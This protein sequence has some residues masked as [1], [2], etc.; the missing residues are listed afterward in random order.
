MNSIQTIPSQQDGNPTDFPPPPTFDISV[1]IPV[2]DERETI[3]PLYERICQTLETLGEKFEIVWID[4]GST[5]GSFEIMRRLYESDERVRA[6][7]FRVNYG[8][9][10]ALAAGFK[11]ARGKIIVTID[12]D[13]QDDPAEIPRLL[14]KLGEGYDLVSGWKKNRKDPFSKRIFSR[15]FNAAVSHASGIGLHDINSGLKCYRREVLDQV[16]LYGEMHRFLPVMASWYGFRTAEVE[17]TH[18]PRRSGRSKYGG[19]R[20]IKGFLDFGTVMFF[21]YYVQRPSHLFGRIGLTIG[22]L[23]FFL[24]WTG[25]FTILYGWNAM[26]GIEIAFSLISILIGFQCLS[27]G[28]MAEMLTF[29][30][31][32][33]EP[34]YYINERLER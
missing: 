6:Y 24:F 10:P 5:D 33:E 21:T 32:R 13:L 20:L 25:L 26:G 11:Q 22:S 34:S 27:L 7:R 30:H 28:L 1:V 18:H 14:E 8:K 16:H 9:S 19:E 12:A 29:L 3:Q 2:K 31:R 23:G 17:V 15:I 4:D